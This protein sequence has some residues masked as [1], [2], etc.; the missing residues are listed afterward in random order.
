MGARRFF[1]CEPPARRALRAL[2]IR[3]RSL[4]RVMVGRPLPWAPFGE[5]RSACRGLPALPFL[6][7]PERERLRYA[8]PHGLACSPKAASHN[9]TMDGRGQLVLH[10]HQLRPARQESTVPIRYRQR[11]ARRR[12]VQSREIRLALPPVSADGGSSACDRCLP[13]WNAND[14]QELEEVRCRTT[15]RGVATRFFRSP[16]AGSSRT[17]RKS[18][19]HSHESG[20][21]R[22]VRASRRLDVGLSVKQSPAAELVGR[23][24]W[25]LRAAACTPFH[26][27]FTHGS[28]GSASPNK[29]GA[30]GVIALPNSS[31][32]PCAVDFVQRRCVSQRGC[33]AEFFAKICGAHDAAHHFAL[34]VLVC[35]RQT[36]GHVSSNSTY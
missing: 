36:S 1:D 9:S 30:H 35:R 25:S 21:E 24:V 13:T 6:R 2:P 18:E 8:A 14:R 20:S 28:H 29:D 10:L 23:A 33:I 27:R 19:L 26:S 4:G 11:C 7:L 17:R 5:C 31:F 32:M 3:V 22:V 16:P 15:S 12:E 34:R